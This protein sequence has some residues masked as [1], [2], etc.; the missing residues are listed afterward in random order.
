M[1]TLATF[2]RG[3]RQGILECEAA[4]EEAMTSLPR[5]GSPEA[6]QEA[7]KRSFADGATGGASTKLQC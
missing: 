2:D 4:I 5:R 3:V 1:S 7:L 6:W